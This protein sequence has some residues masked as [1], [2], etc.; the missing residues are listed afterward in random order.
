MRRSVAESILW[1]QL[2]LYFLRRSFQRPNANNVAKQPIAM[3]PT[4]CISISFLYNKKYTARIQPKLVKH[5][6]RIASE[7]N[8]TFNIR[9]IRTMASKCKMQ[10]KSKMRLKVAD[11]PKNRL[12]IDQALLKINRREMV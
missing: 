7:P 5:L 4:I 9:T 6:L 2:G 1:L 12:K 8:R 3:Y 11:P 10:S